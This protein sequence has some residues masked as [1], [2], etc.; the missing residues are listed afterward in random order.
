MLDELKQIVMRVAPETN[1]DSVRPETRLKED[2][3]LNSLSMIMMAIEIEDTFQISMQ[4]AEFFDTVEDVCRYI[5]ERIGVD[6]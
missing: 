1:L 6:T 2:L 3:G 5:Q 4:D